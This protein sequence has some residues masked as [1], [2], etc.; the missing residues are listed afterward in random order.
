MGFLPDPPNAQYATKKV[1]K[2]QQAYTDSLKT[3]EYDYIFPVLGQ[4]AYKQ[5]FDIPYSV[6]IMANYI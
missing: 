6:G 1:S 3:Y 5:G 4:Q 2:K